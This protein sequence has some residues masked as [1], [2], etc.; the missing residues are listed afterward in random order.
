VLIDAPEVEDR[1]ARMWQ[2]DDGGF[3]IADEDTTAGTWVNYQ[4]VSREGRQLHHGDI[5][6]IGLSGYRF[7]LSD[8]VNP[9]QPVVKAVSGNGTELKR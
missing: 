3:H 8:P 6:H 1:H 5:V 7:T 4:P 2:D 9:R